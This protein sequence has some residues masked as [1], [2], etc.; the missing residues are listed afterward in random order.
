MGGTVKD[1]ADTHKAS[2]GG[3]YWSDLVHGATSHYK[4]LVME[5]L[6]RSHFPSKANS[7][8]DIGCG[9]CATVLKYREILFASRVICTDYDSAIV[10]RMKT[11]H[12]GDNVEWRTADIFD[13]SDL[14]E[15]F[16]LVFLMDMIHEVY[17]FY[18]RPNR[19]PE[20]EI[21]HHLGL[22]YVERAFTQ[23]ASIVQPGGGILITDD[24]LCEKNNDVTIRIRTAATKVAVERFLREYPSKRIEVAFIDAATIKLKAR[25]LNILLTQYNKIKRGDWERWNIEKMEIH[26][27][28]SPNEFQQLFARLGFTTHSITGTPETAREEWESD[29]EVVHGMPS[30]PAKRITVLA[31]K[32]PQPITIGG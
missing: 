10:E 32:D 21:D 11:V 29:F 27:Y 20:E 31:I 3:A 15:R 2:K 17:S 22:S 4:E 8:I 24:V 14:G 5:Q 26:E 7:L 13:L 16:D 1:I 25:D 12:A 6:L 23:V 30:L 18:G 9:T 19:I 28:M